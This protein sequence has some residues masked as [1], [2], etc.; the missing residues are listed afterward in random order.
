MARNQKTNRIDIE[1]ATLYFCVIVFD[2]IRKSRASRQPADPGEAY[3][4]A[5]RKNSELF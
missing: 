5:N 1:T 2:A 3:G 4:R